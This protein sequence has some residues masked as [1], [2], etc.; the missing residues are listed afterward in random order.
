MIAAVVWWTSDDASS[1]Q[2]D[3]VD[4]RFG[5]PTYCE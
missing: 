2:G 1:R 3:C 4:D 5:Q